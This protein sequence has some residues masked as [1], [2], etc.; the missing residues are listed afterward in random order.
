MKTIRSGLCWHCVAW[1]LKEFDIMS[2]SYAG[3]YKLQYHSN[4]WK[5]LLKNGKPVGS[6][7]CRYIRGVYDAANFFKV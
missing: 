6:Y 3:T 1:K 2:E 7:N 4:G 5:T